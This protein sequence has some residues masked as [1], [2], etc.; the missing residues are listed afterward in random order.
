MAD[1]STDITAALQMCLRVGRLKDEGE[2]NPN[3]V[4]MIKRNSCLKSLDVARKARDML[5]GNGKCNHLPPLFCQS[6]LSC[7]HLALLSI[8]PFVS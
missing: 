4:S 2:M 1:M 6:F 7:N 3:M 8:I 5:G